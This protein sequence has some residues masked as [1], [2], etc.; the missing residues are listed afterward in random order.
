MCFA[1]QTDLPG[2][3][4][5]IGTF[6]LKQFEVQGILEKGLLVSLK[7]SVRPL[8]TTVFTA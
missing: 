7:H 6:Y 8:T 2:F 1:Q 4:D 3:T 5:S